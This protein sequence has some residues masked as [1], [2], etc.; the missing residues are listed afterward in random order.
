MSIVSTFPDVAAMEKMLEMGM[1]Q[2]LR[3]AM[4]QIDAILAEAT[5]RG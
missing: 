5:V 3:E 4:G 1:E 2:G